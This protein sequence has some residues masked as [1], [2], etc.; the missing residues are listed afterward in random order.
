MAIEE[1]TD[2]EIL[3]RDNSAV[4]P[5]GPRGRNA[6]RT[7]FSF[8]ELQAAIA[9]W[10]DSFPAGRPGGVEGIDVLSTGEVGANKFL[11]E[12]G[13]GTSSWQVGTGGGPIDGLSDVDTTTDVPTIGDY[14]VF[15]GTNW[16]TN[17]T[18][19]IK[20]VDDVG[21]TTIYIGDAQP[22][23]VDAA[24]A[25]R[26]KRIVF[27]GDDSITLFA[28]GDVNFDNTWTGRAGFAYS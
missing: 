21:G 22:G 9:R 14:L 27:T 23:T 3:A 17:L 16:V 8:Q 18:Q 25:W 7:S 4:H 12:D 15:D 19:L 6:N 11:R 26:V 10:R 5:V 20:Q 13:D 24:A 2:W 28:D 1:V